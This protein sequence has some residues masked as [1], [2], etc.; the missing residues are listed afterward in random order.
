MF[1]IY[2]EFDSAEE[3]NK[4]AEGQLKQ[5][6]YEAIKEIAKENGLDTEDAEDYIEGCVQELCNPLMA[7]FGKIKI[8]SEELEPKEIVCDWIEYIRKKCTESEEMA[9]AVRK[10]G[11]TLEGCIAELLKWS[12]KNSY[13]IDEKIKKAAGISSSVK[14]GIPGM[15]T[16]YGLIEKYYLGGDEE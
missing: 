11:K 16:A 14:M 12:F 3:I 13:Y 2:G 4:A 8:E 6:D 15:A 7:A 9:E 1:D 5:G 10:K